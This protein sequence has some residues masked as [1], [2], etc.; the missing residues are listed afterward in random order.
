MHRRLPISFNSPIQIFIRNT[1]IMFLITDS[2]STKADWLVL[3]GSGNQRII[4]TQGFNPFL[5][6]SEFIESTLRGSLARDLNVDEVKEVIYYGAGCSDDYR[7][8]IVALAL[9]R[10]FTNAKVTVEHDLLA[11]ARAVCGHKPG[12]ACILGTGSNSCIYDG[13]VVT[14]N[15]TNLG[16][17]LGD[18]GSGMHLGKL[19]IQFYFYRE[20]PTNFI[21]IFEKYLGSNKR[22]ILNAIYDGGKANVYLASHAKFMAQH[23]AN[24]FIKN[25]IKSGFSEFIN[26]HVKKYL[27]SETLPVSFVGSIAFHFEEILKEVL[28]ENKLTYGKVV[29][30]P[31]D[32]LAKFHLALPQT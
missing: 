22:S 20:M 6:S 32:E 27:G 29:R 1:K 31:I 28:A 24:P 21:P 5:H 14:D 16:H 26:R 2:G 17:L 4:N 3:D 12:I 8:E 18:E 25:L 23:Q 9:Q 30:K 10:L 13:K 7:C 15:V 19:L 11:S